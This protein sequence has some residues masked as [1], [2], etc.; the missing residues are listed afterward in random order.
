M[1]SPNGRSRMWDIRADGYAR[2]EGFAAV[3]IKF[4]SKSI[5]D[6]DNVESVIRNT[7]VNQDGRSEGLTVPSANAQAEL[8]RSTYARCGLD[9]LKEEDRCQY[10]EAHGTGN[11]LISN[12]ISCYK[13]LTELR[14][15]SG[16]PKRSRGHQ[17]DVFP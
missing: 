2:G 13:F 1:L 5:A 3:V 8:M 14:H 9:C 6:G 15:E 17:R 16:R 4:L 10:F 11:S 12:R 7:G